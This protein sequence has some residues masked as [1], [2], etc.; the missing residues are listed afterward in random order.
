MLVKEPYCLTLAEYR[1]LTD[2]QILNV[3]LRPKDE[4]AGSAK[5]PAFDFAEAMAVAAAEAGMPPPEV[6]VDGQ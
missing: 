4:E 5:K 3:Y 1:D 6:I 2:W